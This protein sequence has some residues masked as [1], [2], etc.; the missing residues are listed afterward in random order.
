[1]VEFTKQTTHYGSDS[2][3][4][5]DKF[6]LYAKL[7]RDPINIFL[8]MEEKTICT[9]T[10]HYWVSRADYYAEIGDYKSAF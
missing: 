7:C 3:E 8:Y 9:F 5:L 1:M 2:A 4:V 10:S 6:L